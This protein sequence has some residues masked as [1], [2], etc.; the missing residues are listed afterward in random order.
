MLVQ[1]T[2]SEKFLQHWEHVLSH[3]VKLLAA[4]TLG[5]DLRDCCTG[6]CSYLEVLVLQRVNQNVLSLADCLL[7]RQSTER[8]D[9]HAFNL[10]LVC[11][12][13]CFLIR[14]LP[15]VLYKVVDARQCFRQPD[16]TYCSDNDLF[17]LNVLLFDKLSAQRLDNRLADLLSS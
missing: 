3:S 8:P 1:L 13:C 16:A 6:R 12:R 5:A 15:K 9:S 14:L 17:H 4:L 2:V 10:R 7:R 11:P